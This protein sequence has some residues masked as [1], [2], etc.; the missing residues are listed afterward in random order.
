L[1]DRD[2]IPRHLLVKHCLRGVGENEGRMM[3]TPALRQRVRFM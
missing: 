2:D 3:I 1:E